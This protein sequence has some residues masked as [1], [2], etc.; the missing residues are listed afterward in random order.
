[1]S[2]AGRPRKR[3][4]LSGGPKTFVLSLI[5]IAVYTSKFLAHLAEQKQQLLQMFVFFT[6]QNTNTVALFRQVQ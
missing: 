1:M 3:N 5:F 6:Y 4:L 2:S